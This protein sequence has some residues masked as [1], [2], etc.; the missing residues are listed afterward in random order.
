ME[1]ESV[2]VLPEDQGW[3]FEPKWDGFRCLV[4]RD[5]DA[6][7][8]QSK[9]CR[10]LGR[11]FPEVVEA[12]LRSKQG[13]FVLDAELI[14]EADGAI[15]F[16]A[17]QL[18]LH[19]AESRIRKLAAATPARLILFDCLELGGKALLDR[20]FDERRAPLERFH[21]A[22]GSPDLLLSP[23][24]RDRAAASAWLGRAGAA[25]DG[26]VAKRLDE[27]YRPGER[28]LLKVKRLRT[29]DCVVGGFR[30]ASKARLVGSLLLGLYDRAGRL[31][32]VG[33]TSAI[34]AKEKVALTRRLEALAGPP[35]FTGR[36][37]GGPSRWSTERSA[38]WEPLKPELVAEVC[39]DHISGD[40]FRHG[41]RFLRWRPDKAPEQ[42]RMDQLHR[43]SAPARLAAELAA[44]APQS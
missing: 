19:P 12:V 18:R 3:Q 27:P 43:E 44:D 41:T 23:A 24:T 8:L 22:E 1:A 39:Y 34:P 5:G 25:L 20:P 38:A 40:R 21:S 17:P 33:F 29:A 4:F 36:A 32:H 7:E 42:C 10:P 11:Y 37:P 6:V 31:N 9:A 16:E 30:Y 35:G 26:V 15:S 2:E 28:A 14:I 13:R